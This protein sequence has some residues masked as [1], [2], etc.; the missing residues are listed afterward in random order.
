MITHTQATATENN[1]FYFIGKGGK[2]KTLRRN[3]KTQTWKRSPERFRIPV[4]YGLYEYGNITEENA[5][6][7]FLTPDEAEQ[8]KG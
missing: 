6:L 5:H 4:K 3:G 8:S 7:F 2:V 1:R